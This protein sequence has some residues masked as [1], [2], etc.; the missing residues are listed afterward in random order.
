MKRNTK[1]KRLLKR[2]I[3]KQKHKKIM[4]INKKNK[5]KKWK[6]CDKKK[7]YQNIKLSNYQQRWK[8]LQNKNS[9]SNNQC[10]DFKE[11]TDRFIVKSVHDLR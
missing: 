2:N 8:Q 3:Q 7:F 1:I 5:N 6:T 9:M 10:C 11:F 4:K